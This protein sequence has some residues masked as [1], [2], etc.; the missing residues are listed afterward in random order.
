MRG[1]ACVSRYY[2]NTARGLNRP[3]RRSC[4]QAP[5]ARRPAEI[6]Y[7][8]L[9]ARVPCKW[10]P[11]WKREPIASNSFRHFKKEA[12][13]LKLLLYTSTGPVTSTAGITG[14]LHI[15][16]TSITLKATASGCKTGMTAPQLTDHPSMRT[17]VQTCC[18]FG[19]G[20]QEVNILNPRCFEP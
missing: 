19:G 13:T 15:A 1:N 5:G 20:K 3:F 8:C 14:G 6:V 17:R 7:Y 12:A 16:H 4:I 11:V 2:G 18:S 9:R 10:T